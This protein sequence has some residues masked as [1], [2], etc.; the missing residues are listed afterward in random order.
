VF[1]SG[2][3]IRENFPDVDPIGRQIS[4]T[5]LGAPA[6]TVGVVGHVKQWGLDSD[7]TNKIRNQV[8]FPLL[9]VPDE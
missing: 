9:Q 5:A 1:V 4:L 2:C 6:Q 7:D 8:Y 3:A